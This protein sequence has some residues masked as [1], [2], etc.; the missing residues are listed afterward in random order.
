[1]RLWHAIMIERSAR[2]TIGDSETIS[3][4]GGNIETIHVL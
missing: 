2:D 4:V 3:R 1:M